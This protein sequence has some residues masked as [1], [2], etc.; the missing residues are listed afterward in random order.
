VNAYRAAYE[1]GVAQS[2]I[3]GA[4]NPFLPAELHTRRMLLAQC[5]RA[6]RLH[7]MPASFRSDAEVIV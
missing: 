1:L 7:D 6:G 4:K 5:W 2:R 3:L